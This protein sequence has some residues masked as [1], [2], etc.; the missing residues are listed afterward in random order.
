MGRRSI[1][2]R[3]R[4]LGWQTAMTGIED[5][6]APLLAALTRG[7]AMGQTVPLRWIDLYAQEYGRA[8]HAAVRAW[9]RWS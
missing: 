7:D 8:Y 5:T 4:R 3:A 2:R 6:E 1:I 9:E